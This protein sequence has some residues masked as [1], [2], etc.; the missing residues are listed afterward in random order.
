MML[1]RLCAV[2]GLQEARKRV[3]PTNH[4]RRRLISP[5]SPAIWACVRPETAAARVWR[6]WDGPGVVRG[7]PQANH[8]PT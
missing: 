8:V 4:R 1:R 3:E 6:G 5:V 2:D 7:H